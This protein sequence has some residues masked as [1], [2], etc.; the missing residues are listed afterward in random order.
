MQYI[1]VKTLGFGLILEPMQPSCTTTAAAKTSL[2]KWQFH[3]NYLSY[4]LD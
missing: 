3:I 4:L 1:F 2:I